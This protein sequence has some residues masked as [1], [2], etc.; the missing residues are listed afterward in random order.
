MIEH[1]FAISRDDITAERGDREEDRQRYMAM[2]WYQHTLHGVGP[3]P[4]DSHRLPTVATVATT[5]TSCQRLPAHA[6]AEP[7]QRVA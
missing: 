2:R 6:G 7:A 4:C 5:A 1:G 3:A